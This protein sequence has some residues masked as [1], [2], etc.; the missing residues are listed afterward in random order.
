MVTAMTQ[1]APRITSEMVNATRAVILLN[2]SM[3]M[4]IV[5]KLIETTVRPLGLV[6]DTATKFATLLPSE[7]TEGTVKRKS[8]VQLP[9]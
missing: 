6:M 2:T 9:E 8:S 1:I 4:V 3:I 5:K 7:M